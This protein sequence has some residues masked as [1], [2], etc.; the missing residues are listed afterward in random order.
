MEFLAKKKQIILQLKSVSKL[1]LIFALR[2]KIPKTY[3]GWP[4]VPI[5]PL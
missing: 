5:K 1:K 2:T 3:P 4:Q